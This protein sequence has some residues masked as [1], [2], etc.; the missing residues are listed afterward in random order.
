M[1][2]QS[3]N[4]KDISTVKLDHLRAQLGIV[5]QEPVL[6]D[7]TIAENIAYG[8]NSREV[9][10]EEIID[11][12]KKSNIHSFVS[13]LPLVSHFICCLHQFH[14]PASNLFLIDSGHAF[15]LYTDKNG[16]VMNLL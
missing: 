16:I 3:I 14:H 12:A 10:M 15:L 5:S 6:F 9:P 7:R 2:L 8:D 4:G 13:S 11:A 1:Y